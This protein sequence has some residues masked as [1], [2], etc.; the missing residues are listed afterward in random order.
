MHFQA[1]LDAVV[2]RE[3]KIFKQEYEKGK[4]VTEVEVIGETDKSGTIVTFK[5]DGTIFQTTEFNFEI[6]VGTA[7]GTGI[8]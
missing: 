4:P 1:H 8:S 3:G 5:P 2:M 7:A 6:L